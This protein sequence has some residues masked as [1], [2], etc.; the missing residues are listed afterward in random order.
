MMT[1]ATLAAA[2]ALLREKRPLVHN[3]T[4]AVVANF[5]ANA[6]LALGAAPAMAEGTDEVAGFAAT[7]DAVVINLGMLTPDRATP[8]PPSR[9]RGAWPA[10][11][12]PSS[13]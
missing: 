13:P 12:G 1:S 7:A 9:R 4:N 3:L 10:R 5:T 2:L 6:L 8:T 11:R